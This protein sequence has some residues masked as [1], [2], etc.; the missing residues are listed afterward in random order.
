[1]FNMKKPPSTKPLFQAIKPQKDLGD[2]LPG[3]DLPIVRAPAEARREDDFYATGEPEALRAL[4]A[5][6]GA[7]IASLGAVWEPAAGAGDMVRV[8]RDTGLR[9]IA[10]DIVDRGCPDVELRSY[11]DYSQ[12]PARVIITNPP[13]G[14][15]SA[16]GGHG[17]WL[18]HAVNLPGWDYM[19]LLLSWEWPA[20][21]TNGLGGLLEQHAFSYCYLCRWKIDFTGQGRPAQRNAWFIWDKSW[22]NPESGFRFLDRDDARQGEFF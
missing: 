6:D 14:E 18:R 22:T 12:A 4:L 19:A 3:L 5:R 13:Y 8:I 9:C 17:R 11:Y 7:R 10:S 20:G 21:K 16:G 1:M 2:A 15:I